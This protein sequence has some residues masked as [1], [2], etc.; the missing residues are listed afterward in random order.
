MRYLSYEETPEL[1]NEQDHEENYETHY[2]DFIDPKVYSQRMQEFMDAPITIN[3][4]TKKVKKKE[5]E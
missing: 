4:K 2:P 5:E 1:F 3:K